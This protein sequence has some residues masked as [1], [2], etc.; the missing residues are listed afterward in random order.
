MGYVLGIDVGGTFTDFVAYDEVSRNVEAWKGFSTRDNPADGVLSGLAD[1]PHRNE[2]TSIRLGTT[3][4][5]NALLER[6]GAN[7]AFVTT[8]GFRDVPFI[9]RGNRRFHFNARWVKSAPF[10]RRERCY[11]VSE[12]IDCEGAVLTPISEADLEAVAERIREAGDVE[13]IAVAFLFSYIN[14]AHEIHARDVLAAR[15]PDLPVSASFEV[16]PKWKEYERSSTTIADAYVKPI[17]TRQLKTLEDR[18]AEVAPAASLVVTKSNGGQAS[19]AGACAAPVQMTLSG[20]TGGVVAARFIGALTTREN[21][22]TLDMGGTS[23]DCAIAIGG[24][25]ELTTDFEIEFGIPIQIPMVDVRTIGAGGGSIAWVDKGGLLRVGPQSAGAEPGPVCYGRGGTEP[26]VTDAN[27]VLGRI[28]PES[29]L[30][31]SVALD[32]EAARA[33]FARL[34]ERFGTNAEEAALAVI[35]IVNTN[36]V[37]AVRTTLIEKGQDPSRFALMCFGG[38]GPLHAGDLAVMLGSGEAIVPVHPGQFSA[39]GFTATDARVDRQRT[40]QMTSGRMDRDRAADVLATLEVECREQLREQTADGDVRISRNLDMRYHGQNYELSIPITADAFAADRLD[41]LWRTFHAAH[42]ARFGF[43]IPGEVVE[44]VNF[45]VIAVHE[46]PKPDLPP[47]PR[48][49]GPPAPVAT[50]AVVYTDG[51]RDTPVYRREHL[52][53]GAAL[54]GPAIIEETVTSTL[55]LASQHLTVDAI[56]NLLITTGKKE[57]AS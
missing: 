32:V 44:I 48:Q 7:V 20:P 35:A 28:N 26:T 45:E 30:G 23:T 53:A 46:L 18:L 39:F 54:N 12:R 25:A 24:E 1:F 50:R 52:G 33:A 22:V 8:R 9:Q 38:A 27:L 56:G 16:L 49:A 36:M 55:V 5:T 41:D 57:A 15:F 14:P 4:A 43:D 40:V 17:V 3:I 21:F 19:V 42:K 31:G 47:L 37:G 2:V 10:I 29:F 6:R 13:A 51:K 34:G 11:E